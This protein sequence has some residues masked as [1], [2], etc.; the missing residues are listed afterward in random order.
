MSFVKTI[1]YVYHSFSPARIESR[2]LGMAT[3]SDWAA[4]Y[5]ANDQITSNT[6]GSCS[7]ITP[8]F[9]TGIGNNALKR[10][11]RDEESEDIQ[12]EQ[13]YGFTTQELIDLDAIT[14][15]TLQP[16]PATSDARIAP[17]WRRENWADGGIFADGSGKFQMYPLPLGFDGDWIAKNDVV[18]NIMEPILILASSLLVQ[19][20]RV[21][22][23]VS[24]ASIIVKGCY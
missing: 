3:K 4:K 23:F 7:G 24:L 15:R 13:L 12:K 11:P 16:P 20:P 8:I 17:F 19:N 10:D 2:S 18:W 22:S 21:T 9:P 5:G 6:P 14:R 1:P